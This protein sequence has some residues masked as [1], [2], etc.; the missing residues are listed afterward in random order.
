MNRV[1][2]LLLVSP[3]M[4]CQPSSPAG[5]ADAAP[6]WPRFHFDC[7]FPDRDSYTVGLMTCRVENRGGPLRT[8]C[9]DVIINCEG[10]ISHTGRFCVRDLPPHQARGVPIAPSGLGPLTYS[11]GSRFWDVCTLDW[12]LQP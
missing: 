11:L 10:R 9:G 7:R 6:A 1:L 2:V 5:S 3:L 4:A 8:E 12:Q